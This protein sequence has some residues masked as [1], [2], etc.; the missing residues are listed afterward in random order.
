MN[1]LTILALIPVSILIFGGL[2]F[3]AGMY[4]FMTNPVVDSSN[5]NN[6]VRVVAFCA[7][8]PAELLRMVYKGDPSERCPFHYI[9][10]DEFSDLMDVRSP[11]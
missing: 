10:K 6:W 5:A 9:A 8:H 1:W 7:K 4:I 2:I 11:K 3:F